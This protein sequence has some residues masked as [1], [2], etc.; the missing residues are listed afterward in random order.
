MFQTFL[1][2]SVACLLLLIFFV[3][4]VY[5][6]ISFLTTGEMDLQYIKK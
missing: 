5:Y 6:I 2:D 3:H 1:V 4:Y